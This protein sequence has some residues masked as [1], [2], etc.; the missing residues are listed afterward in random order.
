MEAK[1]DNS[2][3]A[4]LQYEG[5][6]STELVLFIPHLLAMQAAIPAEAGQL[7]FFNAKQLLTYIWY[8]ARTLTS[9]EDIAVSRLEQCVRQ[10]LV[11][12]YYSCLWRNASDGVGW[13][14]GPMQTHVASANLAWLM[15][16]HPEMLL[17]FCLMAGHFARDFSREWW[18]D[19]LVSVRHQTNIKT[20][21]EARSTLESKLL[22]TQWLDDPAERF[23]NETST[24]M[25]ELRLPWEEDA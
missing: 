24:I 15:Q 12:F 10:T 7:D 14:Y 18:L 8:N 4:E 2:V 13:M 17:W 19:L 22:W 25:Q 21:V 23:W 3:F 6:L 5:L 1:I 9:F 20:F 16:S 11:I